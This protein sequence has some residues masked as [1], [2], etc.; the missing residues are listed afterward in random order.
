MKDNGI[1]QVV[2]IALT[3]AVST[4][5]YTKKDKERYLLHKSMYLMPVL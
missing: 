1:F 4:S 2:K 5:S 3:K